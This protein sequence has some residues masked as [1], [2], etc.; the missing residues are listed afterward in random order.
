MEWILPCNPNKFKIAAALDNL[1]RIDWFTNCKMCS[2]DI[3]YIYLSHTTKSIMYRCVA[4]SDIKEESTI[5]DSEYGGNPPGV[6]HKCIE[7]E[8]VEEYPSPGITY[9]ELVKVGVQ[10][11]IQSP[12][13]VQGQL[14]EYIHSWKVKDSSIEEITINDPM[15][16]HSV[17]GNEIV[18]GR[19]MKR[20]T[21]APRCPECGQLV[22]KG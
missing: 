13:K 14:A 18:C 19:C 5:D 21:N 20:F 7:I 9:E 17:D 6:K 1:K 15:M 8:Y 11:S 3:C 4:C 2:G 16:P 12:R 22:K 10:G